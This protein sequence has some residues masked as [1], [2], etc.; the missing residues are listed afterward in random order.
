MTS[1]SPVTSTQSQLNVGGSQYNFG[2]T[3]EIHPHS[4]LLFLVDGFRLNST[5]GGARAC[6]KSYT[7]NGE[8]EDM[9]LKGCGRALSDE[10]DDCLEGTLEGVPARVCKCHSDKC[11][12]GRS[13]LPSHSVVVVALGILLINFSQLRPRGCILYSFIPPPI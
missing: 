3:N 9:V 5:Q 8:G 6:F 10:V 2:N 12:G 7:K 1:C 11:N 4:H 13:L